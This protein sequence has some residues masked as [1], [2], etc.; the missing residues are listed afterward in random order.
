MKVML[1]PPP[2]NEAERLAV[3][4]SYDVVGTAPAAVQAGD[5]P[6][7]CRFLSQNTVAD[8]AGDQRTQI[9]G[10][11]NTC[12]FTIGGRFTYLGALDA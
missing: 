2:P 5:R 11:G 6:E 9:V 10:S 4:A 8:L 12:S 7:P 3:L 1:P